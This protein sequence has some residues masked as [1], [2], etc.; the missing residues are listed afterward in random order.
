MHR[1]A[2]HR[3]AEGLAWSKRA[4]GGAGMSGAG[5]TLAR[6][7]QSDPTDG[8]IRR[9]AHHIFLQLIPRVKKV[10]YFNVPCWRADS[11]IAAVLPGV[12]P[13]HRWTADGRLLARC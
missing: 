3:V 8:R 6:E 13:L 11:L 7:R 5:L 12:F 10:L 9:I 4:S 2:V 1:G